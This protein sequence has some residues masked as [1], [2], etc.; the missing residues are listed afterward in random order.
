[1]AFSCTQDGPPGHCEQLQLLLVNLAE[2][3]KHGALHSENVKLRAYTSSLLACLDRCSQQDWEP[4]LLA[5]LLQTAITLK[6]ADSGSGCL[7]LLEVSRFLVINYISR[8][9]CCEDVWTVDSQERIPY[10][11]ARFP[12]NGIDG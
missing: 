12:W 4:A 1:M 9:V 8:A 6:E 3:V 5:T 2:G 10:K 11:Q 7:Q